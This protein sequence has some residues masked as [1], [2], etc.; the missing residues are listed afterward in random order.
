[1]SVDR[2]LSVTRGGQIDLSAAITFHL[3]AVTT[4]C[5]VQLLA[6]DSCGQVRP[7]RFSC[8]SH[9]GP[10]LYQHSGC[11]SEIELATFL[12]S[13]SSRDSAA[14]NVAIF[15]VEIMIEPVQPP[16]TEITL[17]LLEG[18][19][20]GAA[21]EDKGVYNYR[22]VF[23]AELIGRCHYE[24][25][26]DWQHMPLPTSGAVIGASNQP[27][28]CGFSD[29]NGLTYIPSNSSPPLG[30]DYLLVKLH[31]YDQHEHDRY[32]FLPMKLGMLENN[33]TNIGVQ[34]LPTQSLVVHQGANTPIPPA[35]L[36]FHNSPHF[37]H[38]N[39][40]RPIY[41]YTFPVLNAGSF[42][43]ILSSSVNVTHTT[44]TS[45]DLVKG[46]VAFYPSFSAP[47][48]TVFLYTISNI[49]GAVVA[50]GEVNVTVQR[51]A[52]EWPVQRTNRPLEVMNGGSSIIDRRTIDFYLEKD[53]CRQQATMTVLVPP[54]HGL[55]TFRNGSDVGDTSLLISA[56]RDGEVMVY[57]HSTGSEEITDSIIWE[58]SCPGGSVLQVFTSILVAPRPGGDPPTVLLRGWDITVH[59]GWATPLSPSVIDTF[60]WN[61]RADE[62]LVTV[63][64][65]GGEVVTL[66][67]EE[68]NVKDVYRFLPFVEAETLLSQDIV[69]D[70]SNFSLS[71]LESYSVWYVPSANSSATNQLLNISIGNYTA[72]VRVEIIDDKLNQT[73]YLTTRKEYPSVSRNLPLPLHTHTGTYI[74]SSYL[75][76]QAPPYSPDM[77]VY[78]VHSPPRKG[79]L[80]LLSGEK[81]QTS[82][83]RFTQ[84]DI[85]SQRVYYEPGTEGDIDEDLFVFELT[86]NDFHQHTVVLHQFYF[87]PIPARVE[88]AMD[89]TFY[90]NAGDR[91]A[92]ALRHFKPFS[93][94]LNS[95]DVV[96]QVTRRPHYGHLELRG[97]PNP[98]NFSFDD[99]K[100]R[101]VV[102]WHHLS[103]AKAC[104]DHFSF[105]VENATHSLDGTMRVAIKHGHKDIRVQVDV[106]HHTLYSG[107]RK[108]VFGSDDINVTSSFCLDFVTF[109]LHSLP[110]LGVLSLVNNKHNTV[111]QLKQN[112]T[113]SASDIYSGFLHY[114]FTNASPLRNQISD[115][116]NLSASDPISA[117]PPRSSLNRQEMEEAI[118]HFHVTIIPSPDT[119]YELTINITSP[120]LLTWLPSYDRYGYIFSEND[121]L[122]YNSSI[123]AHQVVIQLEL[124]PEFGSIWKRNSMDN[125][126]TVE[127]VNNGLVWYR[128]DVRLTGF[129]SDSFLMSVIV[130]LMDFSMLVDQKEFVIEWA[131]VQLPDSSLVVSESEGRATVVVR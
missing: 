1:M 18:D 76:S 10:I 35:L 65:H 46:N 102:Y 39:D 82:I 8:S 95:R 62:L 13:S 31:S 2:S 94:F 88:V 28:P 43:S 115:V 9:F 131:T 60:E 78:V 69:Q 30:D 53:L 32:V 70:V 57:N 126:F 4:D 44:F 49:A 124:E 108:F 7:S 42:R 34:E 114:T 110:S 81:C 26:T 25:I 3:N 38:S 104:S 47:E 74:T 117:W 127:D 45:V 105:Y 20:P 41:Q 118:G 33:S 50:N 121:I 89:R 19:E 29:A 66:N 23:P 15:S 79:L 12:V 87:K 75:Y 72:N 107:H 86:M 73:L 93:R 6:T 77:V 68:L 58:V 90:V 119:E 98:S 59:R 130:N 100:Y 99:L 92:I 37:L 27:L 129:S 106:G 112:S 61:S 11:L 56:M 83:N 22:I 63:S 67:L 17:R 120:G 36:S 128:S 125:I 101:D 123:E 40:S 122:I 64:Q 91:K 97:E 109:T 113:F 116:F 71:D 54:K 16:T 14:A 24:V 55:L 84:R 51:H 103:A 85:N 48:Q 111:T 21:L 96:F 52:W 5:S 80:C